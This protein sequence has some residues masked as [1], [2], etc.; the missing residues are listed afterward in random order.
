MA[1]ACFVRDFMAAIQVGRAS[2]IGHSLGGVIALHCALRF[3]HLVDRLVLVESA[4]L[5]K[6][7]TRLLGLASLPALGEVLLYTMSPGIYAAGLRQFVHDPSVWTEDVIRLSYH[8]ATQ[9]GRRR[10][11]LRTLRAF[12]DIWGQHAEVYSPI[13]RGLGRIESQ[14]LIL[15]GRQDRALPLAHAHVA[16][17]GLRRARL[18][19]LDGCGHFPMLE[20]TEAF[21][22]AVDTFLAD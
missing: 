19:V 6:E 18:V 5:G 10:A 17:R 7:A 1:L 3:P 9:P 8:L 22:R 4:G 16:A 15:W 2:L 11:H 13:V 14:T 12:G 20:Q 21:V